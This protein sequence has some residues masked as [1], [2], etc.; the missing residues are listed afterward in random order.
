MAQDS[1]NYLTLL[2]A[3][4]YPP[5]ERLA[6]EPVPQTRERLRWLFEERVEARELPLLRRIKRQETGNFGGVEWRWREGPQNG[7]LGELTGIVYF[8]REPDKTL[9]RY[10][11]SPLFRAER[12]DFARSDQ[13]MIVRQW[14]EKI[15]RDVASEGF[16]NMQVPTIDVALPRAGFEQRART[17][18]WRLPS[19]L[20]LR[21]NPAA[22][23][24]LPA[25]SADLKPLIRTFPQ[26]RR[27]SGP[28]PDI[29][30][31]PVTV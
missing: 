2:E 10:T 24:H 13:D 18:G 27:L 1:T 11:Q 16:Y 31:T 20:K 30:R 12:G 6:P 9:A 19:R 15:G 7:G 5:I 26:Q 21:L 22:E 23:P 4:P 25:V 29:A 3:P 17:E 28:V 8:L 14:A